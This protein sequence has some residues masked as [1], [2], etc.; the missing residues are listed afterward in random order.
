ML[1][2]YLKHSTFHHQ[3]N[4]Q[5]FYMVLTIYLSFVGISEQRAT[6]PL[7]SI[8]RLVL[9]NQG[10]ECLQ[11]GTDWFHIEGAAENPDGF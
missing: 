8:S 11:R 9:Y 3:V 7:H 1:P 6:F 10:G 2:K 5:K 4:I